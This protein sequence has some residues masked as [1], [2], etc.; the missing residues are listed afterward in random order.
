MD[1]SD[2]IIMYSALAIGAF[3]IY[4]FYG[5]KEDKI[6]AIKT[7]SDT[8]YTREEFAKEY[9]ES[10]LGKNSVLNKSE[11]ISTKGNTTYFWNSSDINN[12]N[13]AQRFLLNIGI[14]QNWV[15]T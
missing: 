8:T 3:A 11:L 9:G 2:K 14:P 5:T 7:S 13:F 10:S 1:S 12:L 6:N 4:K 15:I